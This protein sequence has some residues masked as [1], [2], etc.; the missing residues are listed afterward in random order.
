MDL[1]TRQSMIHL[2]AFCPDCQKETLYCGK[3]DSQMS[4]IN[5]KELLFCKSCKFVTLVADFKKTLFSK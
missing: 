1:K 4:E 3:I 2:S 5:K